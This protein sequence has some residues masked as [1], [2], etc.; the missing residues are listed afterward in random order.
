MKTLKGEND[1]A[2]HGNNTDTNH[3]YNK[4]V[5]QFVWQIF[6]FYMLTKDYV[7]V[8]KNFLLLHKLKGLDILF[9]S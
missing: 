6:F 8:L 9:I 4:L 3:T 7:F 5:W 1:T 2:E